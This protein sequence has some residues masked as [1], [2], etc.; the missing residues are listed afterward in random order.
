LCASGLDRSGDPR[1]AGDS[2]L[3]GERE[4]CAM[5]RP[6]LFLN[7]RHEIVV[8]T[9]GRLPLPAELVRPLG[10]EPGD[11]VGLQPIVSIWKVRLYRQVLTFPWETAAPGA[12][13]WFTL[14]FFRL[15]LTALDETGALVLPPEVLPLAE[16]DR[17]VL[18]ITA[19]F[20]STWPGV[21]LIPPT[22]GPSP[23]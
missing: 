21:E 8:E 22:P 3:W 23:A 6:P 16:G 1:P 17:V 19:P 9:G 5:I 4:R 11:I 12:R 18:R 7:S 15:P 14:E 2:R 10:L 13:W 20:G